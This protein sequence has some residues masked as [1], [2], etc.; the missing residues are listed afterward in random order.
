M[1]EKRFFLRRVTT[2]EAYPLSGTVPVG[3]EVVNGITLTQHSG[4]R[5]H[6]TVS[7]NDGAAYVQD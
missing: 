6:A 5:L 4:S 2:G 1:N 3:R 7:V